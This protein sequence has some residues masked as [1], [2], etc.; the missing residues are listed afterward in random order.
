MILSRETRA[1][2]VAERAELL[3]T[4]SAAGPEASTLCS[5]WPV[6][7]LAAHLVV[8]EQYAGLPMAV[9]YPLWRLLSARAGQA[10]RDAI[11]GPMLRNMA[12]AEARGW[13][14]LL[15]R[16]SAG[17]PRLFG[18]RVIAEVRLLEEFVHHEDVR[19]ANGEGPRPANAALDTQLVEAMLTMRGIA[20]FA[21]PRH[22]VEV[23]FTDGQTYRL[24]PGPAR[25]RVV[26][27][28]GEVLLWIAGRGSVAA[29]EVTGELAG[30][31]LALRV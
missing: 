12:R 14:W 30:D 11:T 27:R 18:L 21:E 15:G 17:P 5:E 29:V 23:S 22:G 16:L 26:G 3:A 13:D 24:G 7:T 2:H 20:Q 28:P 31:D 19:R 4:F 6:R 8:S 10:M 9:S 1:L 25:T